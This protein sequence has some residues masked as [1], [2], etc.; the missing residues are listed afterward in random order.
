VNDIIKSL[1]T[2]RTDDEFKDTGEPFCDGII[3]D[4]VADHFDTESKVKKLF[5]ESGMHVYKAKYANSKVAR[6]KSKWFI[7]FEDSHA[8][9]GKDF[10][11]KLSITIDK[12]R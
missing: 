4:N 3:V 10:M 5:S 2:F 11:N 8:I 7:R 1:D 9:M 6:D 12:L